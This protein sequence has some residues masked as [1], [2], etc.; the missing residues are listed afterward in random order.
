MLSCSLNGATS[1]LWSLFDWAYLQRIPRFSAV[2]LTSTGWIVHF[3]FSQVFILRILNPVLNPCLFSLCHQVCQLIV[4][5]IPIGSENCSW[6]L[7]CFLILEASSGLEE[8]ESSPLL[9]STFSSLLRYPELSNPLRLLQLS[10]PYYCV[11]PGFVLRFKIYSIP[12]GGRWMP[13]V[14]NSHYLRMAE[15]LTVVFYVVHSGDK[16]RSCGSTSA[17]S[18]TCRNGPFRCNCSRKVYVASIWVSFSVQWLLRLGLVSCPANGVWTCHP[19][20]QPLRWSMVNLI[21]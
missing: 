15:I 7:M 1:S 10:V 6:L 17:V 19:V 2:F 12:S 11:S 3:A 21:L 4:I 20:P 5:S 9:S 14:H 18:W 13:L 8:G 16:C